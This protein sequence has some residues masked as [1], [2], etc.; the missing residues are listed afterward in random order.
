MQFAFTCLFI[1][2][3]YSRVASALTSQ[4]NAEFRSSAT[5]DGR[6]WVRSNFR[7]IACTAVKIKIITGNK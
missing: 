1:A 3:Y 7:D 4:N 5:S 2:F 6:D